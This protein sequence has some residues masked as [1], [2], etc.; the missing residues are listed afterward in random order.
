MNAVRRGIVIV[1]SAGLIVAGIIG[2][3]AT[4]GAWA[5]CMPDMTTE[6]CLATMDSPE[7][8][9]VLGRM[10]MISLGLTVAAS[11]AARGTARMFSVGAATLVL[12]MNPPV[13]YTIWLA[14]YDGHWDF[15]PGYGYTEAAAFALA[16]VLVFVGLI[17][18]RARTGTRS[19]EFSADLV[20]R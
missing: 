17:V 3:M 11:V 2:I 14:V 5:P 19:A 7:H 20:E 9:P 15:P 1:C 13:E 12:L 6:L 4:Y 8:L 18:S 10:W 16:G